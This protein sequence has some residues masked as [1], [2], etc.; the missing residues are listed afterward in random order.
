MHFVFS[1]LE[2]LITRFIAK[3]KSWHSFKLIE[4]S[5]KRHEKFQELA[6]VNLPSNDCDHPDKSIAQWSSQFLFSLWCAL[7]FSCMPKTKIVTRLPTMKSRNW[8]K[9]TKTWTLSPASMHLWVDK[10]YSQKKLFLMFFLRIFPQFRF[11]KWLKKPKIWLW[12]TSR[13]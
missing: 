11:V 5:Y 2:L 4:R 10:K 9:P 7:H 12:S 1:A 8:S 6:S 3:R 13:L